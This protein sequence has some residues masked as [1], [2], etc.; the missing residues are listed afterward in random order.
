MYNEIGAVV[1]GCLSATFFG[2]GI[3]ELALA[4]KTPTLKA[5]SEQAVSGIG[6]VMVG[7]L[8]ALMTLQILGGHLMSGH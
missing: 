6:G 3:R 8:F 1:L 2:Y 7:A 4:Y 5:W